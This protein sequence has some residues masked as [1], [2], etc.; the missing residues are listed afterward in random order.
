MKQDP[1]RQ[2]ALNRRNFIVSTLKATAAVSI[3][4]SLP[5]RAAELVAATANATANPA[6]ATTP[7][8]PNI[9]RKVKV[10]IIGGGPRGNLIGDLMKAHG[11]Y[12]VHA[13]ADYFPEVADVLG[14]KYGTDKAR[15]FS[16]LSGYK[17]AIESGV[18][19]LAILDVPYFYPEQAADAVA[20][21]C[22]V[23][24]AKP[25]AVDVPGT[26]AI[27]KAGEDATKNKRCFLVDYQLPTDPANA[28]VIKRVREGGLGGL[29][30]MVS[31]GK[32]MAF[33]DPPKGPT[34]ASRFLKQ[35]W[36][37]DTALS[38]D[39][40]VSF[41]I[42]I[43]DGLMAV[44]GKMPVAAMGKSRICR[45]EP[46]GDRVDALSVVYEFDDGVQWTHIT[47]C[48]NNNADFTELT[49]SLYGIR[50][51]AHLRYSG[52]VYVRGGEKHYVGQVGRTNYVGAATRNVA[53]FYQNITEGHFENA[54]VK[55]AVDGHLAAI[56]GR[57]AAA[58]GRRLT[59]AELLAE[60]KR[61]E[62]DL[63]GLN[64]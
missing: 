38:G 34:I 60:N 55:R 26:L 46:H 47:Q 6:D 53:D 25:V 57:E 14:E 44:L 13:V 39:T 43:I 29:A 12:E 5:G 8:A 32:N 48:L 1:L 41:D 61:L 16:G 36:L 22:H 2:S 56:L 19:A 54:T 15:R 3:L 7:P 11:G 64:I 52:K 4:S 27:G 42:H 59:M 63:T 24:I 37:S 45:P 21:G 23:Y 17:K 10:G 62:V 51:S 28:E 33:A 18:E 35:V 30:H 31:Y 40:I 58:R 50:A 20:A 49:A 9:T